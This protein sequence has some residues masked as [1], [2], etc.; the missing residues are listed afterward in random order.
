MDAGADVLQLLNASTSIVQKMLLSPLQNLSVEHIDFS[1]AT[2]LS[3]HWQA[4]FN[5]EHSFYILID[6]IIY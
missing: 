2:A 4:K 5:V 3:V 1:G 6:I